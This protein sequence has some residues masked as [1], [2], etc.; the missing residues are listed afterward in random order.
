MTK[1]EFAPAKINL[2]LHVTGQRADGYHLLDSLVVFADI[3]DWIT[4]AAADGLGL[5]VTGPMAAGVPADA[6]NL[7]V[8]AAE[9]AGASD[10]A[11]TL[12]KHL[13]MAAGIG[14]GSSDAAATLRALAGGHVAHMPD[15][16]ALGADVPVCLAA[17]S[18]RM[19]GIGDIVTPVSGVPALPAVLVNPGVSVATPDAFRALER[20]SGAPMPD[21]PTRAGIAEFVA[22]LADQRNDLQVAAERLEPVVSKVVDAVTE[23][24][25]LLSRMSGSGAT[26]FG[27]FETEAAANRAAAALSRANPTW[28]VRATVLAR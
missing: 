15:P 5:T 28:W 9:L 7:V 6:G 23:S 14:G 3:G 8:R 25:A 17:C 4:I 19:S 16:L 26:C 1:A 18:A 22:W 11:I 21:I 12:E 13:P 27:L 10:V 20:R 24:G 2:T